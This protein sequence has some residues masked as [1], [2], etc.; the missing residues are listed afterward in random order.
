[1]HSHNDM[2][3]RYSSHLQHSIHT[4]TMHTH[5]YTHTHKPSHNTHTLIHTQHTHSTHTHTHIYIYTHI[6]TH[7][8]SC[9]HTHMHTHQSHTHTHSPPS[10]WS[11]CPALVYVHPAWASSGEPLVHPPGYRQLL[12]LPRHHHVL[13]PAATH[14]RHWLL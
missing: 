7:T 14:L 8:H 10:W 11:L 13:Q 9:T 5:P 4:H 2:Y 6:H 3:A 1:M 12:A